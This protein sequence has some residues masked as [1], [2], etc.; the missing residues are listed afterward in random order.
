VSLYGYPRPTGDLD[1]WVEPTPENA[2]R[3][4]EAIREFGFN[5]PQRSEAL[6]LRP[7]QIIRMGKPPLRIELLTAISGVEFG[8]CYERRMQITLDETEI[9]VIALDDL[10]RKKRT[11]GRPKDIADLDALEGG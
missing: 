2:V 4:A 5:I 7:N 9:S 3:L 10:R 8:E 1:L 11:A 6:F